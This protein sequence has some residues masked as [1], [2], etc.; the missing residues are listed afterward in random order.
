MDRW[1]QQVSEDTQRRNYRE[2]VDVRQKLLTL[3][4]LTVEI[5]DEE[6]CSCGSSGWRVETQPLSEP[7]EPDRQREEEP[8]LSVAERERKEWEWYLPSHHYLCGRD[9]SVGCVRT[10]WRLTAGLMFLLVL[11]HTGRHERA[12]GSAGQWLAVRRWEEVWFRQEVVTGRRRGAE[13]CTWTCEGPRI[14][15]DWRKQMFPGQRSPPLVWTGWCDP[16]QRR[17]WTPASWHLQTLRIIISEQQLK[18]VSNF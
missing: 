12:V 17:R 7:V 10:H 15:K 9:D 14:P 18:N 3:W 8:E 16:R 13:C 5:N 4:W 11:L 1:Q 6:E 2:C